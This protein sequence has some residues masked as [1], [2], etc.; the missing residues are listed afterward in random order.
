MALPFAFTG[1]IT[2]TGE[3]LDADLAALG[4]LTPIPCTAAG[5]NNITLT[6]LANTPSITAYASFMQFTAI[7]AATNTQAVVAQIGTLPSLPVYKDTGNGPIALSGLEIVANTKLWLMYDPALNAGA[8]GFHLI[9]PPS[10]NTRSAM[11]TVSLSLAAL[12]PQT[13]TTA[14]V[15]V[16][17][18]SIGDIVDIGYPSLVSIGLSWLA[19]VNNPGTVTLNV[20]NPSSTATITPN[21]GFYRVATRGFT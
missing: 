20:F 1:N 2:P 19:Y 8:G 4:A 10:L 5:T 9:S 3:Q 17:P 12:L 18:T 16:S 15:A 6:P 7:A 21:P 11:A 13:G 14:V